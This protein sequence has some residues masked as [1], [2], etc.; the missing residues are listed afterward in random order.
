MEELAREL[1]GAEE[2]ASRLAIA[3]EEAVRVLEGTSRPGTW[4]SPWP[5]WIP[6]GT[7]PPRDG[8]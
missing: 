6:P 3:R 2:Q 5:P 1:A 7:W 4:A 8:G